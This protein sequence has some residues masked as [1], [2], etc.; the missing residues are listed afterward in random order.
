MVDSLLVELV[1]AIDHVV[2]E[3]L[4]EEIDDAEHYDEDDGANVRELVHGT[5]RHIVRIEVLLDGLG[6]LVDSYGTAE[7]NQADGDA[8]NAPQELL[9]EHA[10]CQHGRNDDAEAR[11]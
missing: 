2:V 4:S 9:L 11:C 6:L 3:P 5:I 1:H 10:R 7:R 8:V